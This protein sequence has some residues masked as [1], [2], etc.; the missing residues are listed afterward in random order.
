VKVK[1]LQALNLGGAARVAGDIV[2]TDAITATNL[3]RKG[4]VEVVGETAPVED[5]K[6]A[7]KK[8]KK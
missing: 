1:V 2:E 5:I 3:V 4:W 8:L 7:T 6:P